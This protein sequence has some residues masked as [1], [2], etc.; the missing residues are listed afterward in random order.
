VTD[1]PALLRT[2]VQH[3][4]RFI[5]VGGLAATV[6]GYARLTQAIDVAYDR[7]DDNITVTMVLT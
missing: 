4:V 3:D 2:L 6:H 5:I 7:S 1:F